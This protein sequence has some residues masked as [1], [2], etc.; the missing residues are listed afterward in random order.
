MASDR[1]DED[2]VEERDADD[3]EGHRRVVRFDAEAMDEQEAEDDVE[4]H[5]RV[6]RG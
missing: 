5:R 2:A 4:G 1:Y 6:A 3:T